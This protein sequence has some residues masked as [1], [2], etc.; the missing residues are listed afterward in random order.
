[1]RRVVRPA[2]LQDEELHAGVAGRRTYCAPGITAG[3]VSDAYGRATKQVSVAA[4]LGHCQLPSA[5]WCR[6]ICKES[7]KSAIGN[8]KSAITRL[9]DQR[10]Q[11][12]TRCTVIQLPRASS[13]ST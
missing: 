4:I 3:T 13:A 12:L 1:M 6:P 7:N 8:R 10:C 11:R 2:S 9:G 5:N